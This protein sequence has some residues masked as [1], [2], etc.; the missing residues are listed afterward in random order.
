MEKEEFKQIVKLTENVTEVKGMLNALITSVHEGFEFSKQ[1]DKKIIE[2]QDITN[3]RVTKIENDNGFRIASWVFG[4]WKRA[5]I[6][7]LA[8]AGIL[9]SIITYIAVNI[10]FDNLLNKLIHKIV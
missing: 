5:A 4:N 10:G 2:R 1:S 9:S 7:L 8:A 6:V 3:G